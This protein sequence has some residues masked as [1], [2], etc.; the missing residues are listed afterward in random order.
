MTQRSVAMDL[1]RRAVTIA[2]QQWPEMADAAMEIPL[3][4]FNDPEL[5]RRERDL[6]ETSPLALLSSNEI[7]QPHDY[8]VRNAVGR[9]VLLTRDE[10]GV[11][12]AFMNYCRH[13]GAEPAHDRGNARRFTCPY[14]AWVYDSRGQLVGMPLRDRY[15]DVDL[16]TYGLV[17]LPS[18]ER[19]GFVW[20]VLRPDHP[21]DVSAHLGALDGEIGALGCDKMRYY[22]S[23][24]EERLGANWK[25]VA[26]GV[27]EGL[28][29]PYVHADTFN[30]N[31]QAVN[32]DL[33][34]YDAIGPHVRWGLPMFGREEAKTLKTLPEEEWHP[35]ESIGC[36]W[37][38]S[39]G[40]LLAN[41][42]YG[43]IYADLYPGEHVTESFIRY[44]WLSPLADPPEGMPAPEE[45]A[46]RAARA[47]HQD[48]V[49]WEG[50]GRGLSRGAH[51]HELV[52]PN[53]KGVQLF[54][55]V[56]ARE[57]GYTGLR[58]V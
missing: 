11:A 41:E 22:P 34:F 18:E 26:E 53:E 14:H 16:S 47:V 50:C 43:V 19:H 51:S 23:L 21:I 44:G 10:Q 15:C 48:Q 29:V 24:S 30:L 7:P 17:E 13:R 35:E 6:F 25:S 40:L 49:V 36:I 8:L 31:P 5:A 45:M 1:M 9:S 38:I 56:L 42:L 20:V 4:Y 52:G 28:H 32:V 2:E 46:A 39:P 27:L 54:H 3:G 33:A 55:E 37:L 57:I 12:H 58:Y